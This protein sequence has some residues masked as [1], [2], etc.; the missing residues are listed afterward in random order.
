MQVG[1]SYAYDV[2]DGFGGSV[3]VN[4]TAENEDGEIPVWALVYDFDGNPVRVAL[5]SVEG[6]AD[7][8][9]IAVSVDAFSPN[10]TFWSLG[11]VRVSLPA[12]NFQAS[13]AGVYADTGLYWDSDRTLVLGSDQLTPG[14]A[15]RIA[16]VSFGALDSELSAA[17]QVYATDG[18][19]RLS[20]HLSNG[21]VDTVTVPSTFT[22]KSPAALTSPAS[23]A[24]VSLAALSLGFN[25]ASGAVLHVVN[26]NDDATGRSAWSFWVPG[27]T[28]SFTVPQIPAGGL[29]HGHTYSWSVDSY[30]ID[31]FD[32]DSYLDGALLTGVTDLTT[33]ETR[34]FTVQ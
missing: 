25:G 7:G 28:T 26:L 21:T 20:L 23:N 6:V 22:L 19:G 8:A 24:S 9:S 33:T 1:D 11:N 32:L 29:Q 14:V 10:D 18:L 3:T 13:T 27:G 34:L 15:S 2:Y 31:G 30:F 12:S 16:W 5:D 4:V 17:I